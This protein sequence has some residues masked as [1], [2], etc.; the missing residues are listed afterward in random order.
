MEKVQLNILF[1]QR[2]QKVS[3][4]TLMNHS[5]NDIPRYCENSSIMIR[6]IENPAPAPR[7]AKFKIVI[8]P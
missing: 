6:L 5:I 1:V 4:L 7:V 8:G 3:T 2:L